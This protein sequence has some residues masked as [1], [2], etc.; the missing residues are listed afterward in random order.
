MK[1]LLLVI[2]MGTLFNAQAAT[3]T[4]NSAGEMV[5]ENEYLKI[6][7]VNPEDKVG[8]RFTRG[9][10]LKNI[11]LKGGGK[12]GI[13]V[14]K[15]IFDYHTAFGFTEEFTPS[16]KLSEVVEGKPVFAKIGV[17]IVKRPG[18]SRFSDLP[19]QLF[20][21]EIT[22]QDLAG[23]GKTIVYSQLG[24]DR[25]GYC[26]TLT[27]TISI[28]DEAVVKLV[29]TLT[30]TGTKKLTTQVYIHPFFARGGTPKA[31]WYTVPTNP[32]T[33]AGKKAVTWTKDMITINNFSKTEKWV[34]GG[35]HR[36]GE[37]IG[38]LSDSEFAKV[39]IWKAPTCYALESFIDINLAPGEKQTWSWL[40]Y[41]GRGLKKVSGIGKKGMTA[42]ERTVNSIDVSFL[43]VRQTKPLKIVLKIFN[44][45][46]RL[47]KEMSQMR[48]VS[49]PTKPAIAVFKIRLLPNE[50][51]NVTAEVI[52]DGKSIAIA[53][54][55]I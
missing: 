7:L 42:I 22:I 3:I 20:P 8:C 50:K 2:F 24:E 15:S 54:D 33:A 41:P 55:R 4:K 49:A 10:W 17:G 19:L 30:N 13:L 31:C 46:G 25:E 39:A 26:Y 23:G 53:K 37:V 29:D 1:L 45:R 21:W 44:Q 40:L 35:N 48:G 18:K 6:I 12:T 9:A 27:K 52:S 51:F 16:P 32:K 43:P 5:A 28:T 38:I 47:V 14:D 11:F 34:A 36:T